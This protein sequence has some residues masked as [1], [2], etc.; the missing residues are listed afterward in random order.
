MLAD[1]GTQSFDIVV[2]YKNGRDSFTETGIS[3]ADAVAQVIG[4][5]TFTWPPD[6]CVW[7]V[8]K[9]L[10][11]VVSTDSGFRVYLGGDQD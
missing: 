10:Y 7:Y 2:I 4:R 3:A 5:D 9:R 11:E 6:E 1:S 8:N